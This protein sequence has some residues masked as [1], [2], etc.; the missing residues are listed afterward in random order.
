[1]ASKADFFNGLPPW[2]DLYPEKDPRVI[3]IDGGEYYE[4]ERERAKIMP[5]SVS[6]AE[7]AKGFSII[8]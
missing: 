4:R 7:E 3:K 8:L 5:N 2:T 1:M 6:I